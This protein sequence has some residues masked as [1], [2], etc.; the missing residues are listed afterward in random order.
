MKKLALAFI[1]ASLTG[2]AS[3]VNDKIH[4]VAINSNP[5][6]DFVI[7]NRN[8]IEVSSGRTPQTV[9]LSGGAGYFKG[10]NYS[11]KFKKDG[12]NDSVTSINSDLS[13]WY[14]G[15]LAFGGVIGFLLVD[16]LTG[17]MWDLQPSIS[18]SLSKK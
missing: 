16:P 18:S 4:P 10:E 14:F 3:I 1:L 9:A 12:F 17:A 7:T 15:N 5:P 13:G 8:G 2:C 6:A 11:V